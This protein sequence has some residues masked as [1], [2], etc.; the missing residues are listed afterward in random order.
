MGGAVLFGILDVNIMTTYLYFAN[1]IVKIIV[2]VEVTAVLVLR[3]H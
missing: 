3:R 1:I 2:V